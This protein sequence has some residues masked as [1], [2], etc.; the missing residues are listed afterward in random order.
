MSAGILLYR[1]GS[2][3]LEVFLVH[4]GGPFWAGRE[5]GAWSIPKGEFPP[6]EP[7]LEAA[8]REFHEETGTAVHG[9]FVELQP[10][11]QA[12]GKIV[13]AWAL[14]GDCD[15]QN[16]RSNTCRIEWP[17]GSGQWRSYPEV[18]RAGWFSLA[19]ARTRI[20]KGQIPLLDQLQELFGTAA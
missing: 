15:A 12:G 17:R 5:E 16:I 14:E 9:K 20:I 3:A 4:M 6:E 13:Y 18:D 2:G 10:V 19:E 7:P 1:G 8:R 11:R